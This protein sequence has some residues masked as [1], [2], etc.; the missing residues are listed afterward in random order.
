MKQILV[1]ALVLAACAVT[2]AG[3]GQT[4]ALYLP[5]NPALANRATVPESL[6]PDAATARPAD[7]T[8]APANR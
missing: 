2:L 6:L 1:P 8:S 5:V 7:K 3:C 4:G